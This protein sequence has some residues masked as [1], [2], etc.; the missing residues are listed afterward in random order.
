[1]AGRTGARGYPAIVINDRYVPRWNLAGADILQA[2]VDIA[3]TES[4]SSASVAG[5]DGP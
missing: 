1:M 4:Q 5:S 2:I 3:R